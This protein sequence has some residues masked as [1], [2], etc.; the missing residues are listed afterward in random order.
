MVI[1]MLIYIFYFLIIS[2]VSNSS[3]EEVRN[4]L[5]EVAYS[6][7]MRGKYI[8]Y[9]THKGALFSPE[10]A[11][12]QNI[13]YCVCSLFV[14]NVY[15]ELLNITIPSGSQ[16]LVNYAKNNIGSPES[17]LYTNITEDNVPQFYLYDP[18]EKKKYKTTK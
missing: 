14:K 10:E 13:N 4:C 16:A 7:Y 3:L 15:L 5:K 1:N 17:I 11:T 8:Q 12:S 6:Y 18:N 2:Y 9:N